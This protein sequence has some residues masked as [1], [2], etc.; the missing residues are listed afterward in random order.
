MISFILT[1]LNRPDNLSR[2]FE[3]MY[4]Q[5]RPHEWIIVDNGSEERTV[6]LERWLRDQYPKLILIENY[7]NEGFGPGNNIGAEHANGDIFVFTQPDV[8]FLG[9]VTKYLDGCLYDNILYGH[10]LLSYDTGW[11]RFGSVVVSYLT[12]Y[13]LSCTRNTWSTLGGFDPIYYPADFEDVDLS[14]CA[15]QKGMTLRTVDVPISHHAFGSTWSQFK[16][17]EETTRRN[18]SLFAQKWQLSDGRLERDSQG[19]GTDPVH[20]IRS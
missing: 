12:G 18:R 4:P 13:F 7:K 14:Y 8:M 3:Q 20:V 16:N 17:R 11:N 10:Q 5:S 6:M 15:T 9:D 19:T 1:V 2:F